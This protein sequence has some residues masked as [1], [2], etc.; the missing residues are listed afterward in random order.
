MPDSI[1]P[2]SCLVHEHKVYIK[3][4]KDTVLEWSLDSGMFRWLPHSFPSLL[5][6]KMLVYRQHLYAAA[7]PNFVI[8]WNLQTGKETQKIGPT[9]QVMEVWLKTEVIALCGHQGYLYCGKR[10]GI[11]R[12]SLATFRME[13]SWEMVYDLIAMI[14]DE[15]Y[16]YCSLSNDTIHQ[17]SLPLGQTVRVYRGYCNVVDRMCIREGVLYGGIY[18]MFE[19]RHTL[20]KTMLWDGSNDQNQQTD[21]PIG[22]NTHKEM[23]KDGVVSMIVQD[24][25]VFVFS[26]GCNLQH[27]IYQ[28]SLD[29][30]YVGGCVMEGVSHIYGDDRCF[31]ITKGWS[32]PSVKQWCP[33]CHQFIHTFD[34]SQT[35]NTDMDNFV[36]HEVECAK[37]PLDELYN[38]LVIRKEQ[39]TLD[40]SAP[41]V[42]DVLDLPRPAITQ[43]L[44]EDVSSIVMCYM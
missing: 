11:Q 13:H 4:S 28:W 35:T 19:F 1:K 36:S 44:G 18:N 32:E 24:N 17:V 43:R 39:S 12:W 3:T 27:M 2:V 37:R 38:G 30:N 20:T 29:G 15:K 14:N 42:R 5:P 34:L 9:R 21:N 25:S 10:N 7:Y 41:Y 8:E 22:F 26:Y 23:F 16:M 31:I 40:L 33:R 6:C